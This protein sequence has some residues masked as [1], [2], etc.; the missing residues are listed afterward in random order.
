L[1]F[2]DRGSRLL[3][4]QAPHQS[5]LLV[6]LAER[7]TG[8]Q[9]NDIEAYRRRPPFIRDLCLVDE[10]G[11]ILDFEIDTY[12]H[13]LHFR[14]RL[15]DFG[16]VYQD[17]QTLAFGLPPQVTAG[18]RFHVSPQF[19]QEIEHGGVF[20]SVR[21]LAYASNGDAVRNHITPDEGGYTVEFVVRAGHDCAI[22]L[23]V[24]DSSDLHHD[25]LPYSSSCA[26]A[27]SRWHDWF[28]RIPPVAD[29]YR[30]TYAYAWWI[31][32]NNLISPARKRGLRS[33]D[34]LQD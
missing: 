2:S 5:R 34:A 17:D 27:E 33:D 31:M 19:W 7:L 6:K 10:E 32:A 23:A 1:P 26:A 15:G 21:N 3:V 9:P 8:L 12:P 13:V 30:R 4:Y 16:L 20:K 24:G 29:D 18:L 22:T 28:N 25:V 14:T 11:E